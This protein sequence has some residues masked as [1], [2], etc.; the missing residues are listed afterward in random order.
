MDPVAAL[1][2]RLRSRRAQLGL[3]LAQVASGAG[4]SVP[5]VANLERGRGNPTLDVIVA[6]AGALGI[7]AA[8]LLADD[9][10][11]AV[12]TSY[13]DLPPALADFARGKVLRQEVRRLA[14]AVGMSEVDMRASLLRCMAAIPLPPDADF[15]TTDCRRVIDAVTLV[16]GGHRTAER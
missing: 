14:D 1:G 12:D 6:L 8:S 2:R 15:S 13:A 4:L 11:D 3:T 5:Y 16:A 10:V 9:G 7:A